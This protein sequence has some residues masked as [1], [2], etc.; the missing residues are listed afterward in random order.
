MLINREAHICQNSCILSFSLLVRTCGLCIYNRKLLDLS[1]AT[2][3]TPMLQRPMDPLNLES[4]YP[5]PRGGVRSWVPKAS[6]PVLSVP[7]L[8]SFLLYRDLCVDR[9]VLMNVA[10]RL[11]VE[12]KKDE[13][14]YGL[15]KA[16]W[17]RRRT[18]QQ[19]QRVCSPFIQTSI[20]QKSHLSS[21]K[22]ILYRGERHGACPNELCL[23]FSGFSSFHVCSL[24]IWWYWS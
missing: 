1:M 6:S 9:H 13:H 19:T 14:W 7:E 18:R 16:C 5:F 3:K 10:A 2:Q 15:D 17:G 4:G 20:R 11:Q 12:I 8:S 23:I 22:S 21:R 24:L